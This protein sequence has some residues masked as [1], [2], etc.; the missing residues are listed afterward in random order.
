[1]LSFVVQQIA[2]RF[3]RQRESTANPQDDAS[4]ISSP[5][6]KFLAVATLIPESPLWNMRIGCLWSVCAIRESRVVVGCGV[7]S[8][9]PLLME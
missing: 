3:E 9:M 6:F 5:A 7:S 8:E 2:H 4:A 1:M